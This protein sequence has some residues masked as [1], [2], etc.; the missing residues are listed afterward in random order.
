MAYIN[1]PRKNRAQ[2]SPSERKKKRQS[3]YNTPIWKNLRESVIM[4]HPMCQRCNVNPASEVHHIKPF[5]LKDGTID[6]NRAY[7]AG[8]CMALCKQCHIELHQEEQ[9]NKKEKN[10]KRNG[11]KEHQKNRY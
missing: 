9:K 1:L 2:I 7:S 3:I 4:E 8:N 11:K 6:Y 10:T 5:L